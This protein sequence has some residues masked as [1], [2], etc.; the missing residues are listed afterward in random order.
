[1]SAHIQLDEAAIKAGYLKCLESD[2]DDPAFVLLSQLDMACDGDA[3]FAA[4][5][6]EIYDESMNG[7]LEML[8]GAVLSAN[9][10][11]LCS[12]AHAIKGAASNLG[13]VRV[14][15]A[16]KQIESMAQADECANLEMA[17]ALRQEIGAAHFFLERFCEHLA[18]KAA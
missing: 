16:A 18:T 6:L 3:E 17:A 7:S 9:A 1:M 11:A 10:D 5:L 2:L 14:V 12:A 8:D 13:L 15:A 4:E